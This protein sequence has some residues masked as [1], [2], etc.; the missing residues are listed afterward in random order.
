LTQAL[1]VSVFLIATCG[2][3]Y[4]LLAGTLASYVLGDTVTQFSTVIG[5][6]MFAMGVGSWLSKYV[7]RGLVARFVQVE[8]MVGLVGGFSTTILFLAFGHGFGFRIILYSLVMATGI[9]VGLEIPLLLRILKDRLEFRD[10]V[11]QILSLDYLGA[12]AASILFPIVLVPKLGLIRSAFLF[13]IINAGVALWG[14]YVFREA[15]GQ[16]R[17]VL[18]AQCVVAVAALLAGFI[19]SNRITTYTEQSLYTDDVILARSTPYQRIIVTR[20]HGDVRLFLNGHLQFSS[21]D[22]YRYHEALV[23][24][25]LASLPGASKVLVMG[26]GDGLAVREILKYPNVSQVTLVD[27]DP[28]MTRLFRDHPLLSGLN[29]GA[30]GD[31]RVRIVNDDAFLWVDK[32]DEKFDFVAIDFPDPSNFSLGK[33]YTT[34]FYKRLAEHLNEDGRIVVQSTSP[35]F[36]R[37][38]YWCVAETISSVGL[39]ISP[40]HLYVPS[41]GEWGFVLAGRDRFA[42]PKTYPAGL[43]FI[44]AVSARDM[45]D[46]PPDM[47]RVPVEVNRLNNQILVHYYDEDWHKIQ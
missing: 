39:G 4:E 38:S 1:L 16:S 23:H 15:L 19:F 24:P 10:L 34:A 2:L 28:E 32:N 46:F 43:R 13:G 41:F 3:V 12:L 35:L 45:F 26:G 36:A 30:L 47:A 6:Y 17:A 18:R 21:Q 22:E 27:L 25:G 42:V 8:L 31:P 44:D 7:G 14:T 33:L 40:Y 29:G 20:R 11:S 9:G 5:T 37:R